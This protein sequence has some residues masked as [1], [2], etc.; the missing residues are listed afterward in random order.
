M[1]NI[2]ADFINKLNDVQPTLWP[3][4]SNAVS[5]AAGAQISF[6]SPLMLAAATNELQAELN[7]PMLVLQFAFADLA[8]NYQAVLISPDTAL[9]MATM[10]LGKEVTAVDENLIADL[11]APLEAIIQGLCMG[12]GNRKGEP[13]VASGL[14]IRYQSFTFPT[15]LLAAQEVV[16]TQVA[17]TGEQLNGAIIW[18]F[19]TAVAAFLIGEQA[20]TEQDEDALPEAFGQSA[21]PQVFQMPRAESDR[22]L[23]ILMDIPLEIS[24]E[25]GRVKMLVRDVVELGTGSIVEI[26][27]AA[28]EP[29]EVLVNGRPVARGEV[30]V[31]EDNFG[32]RITEILNPQE[33]LAKLGEAA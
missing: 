15:N 11:R 18:L 20:P 21:G 30:V 5:E 6:S 32:V 14:S 10:M 7:M 29:V 26:E 28:G 3:Q 23:D 25:L 27:K 12:V 1:S 22:G 24:V 31:I 33:R 9:A 17:M 16:R 8:E 19:D 4:V 13:V 2:S